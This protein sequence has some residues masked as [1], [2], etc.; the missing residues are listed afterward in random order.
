MDNIS[1][2]RPELRMKESGSRMPPDR[3][4][5]PSEAGLTR[6]L[7]CA[8]QREG[9]VWRQLEGPIFNG[10]GKS[11]LEGSEGRHK[12]ALIRGLSGAGRQFLPFVTVPAAPRERR[13]AYGFRFPLARNSGLAPFGG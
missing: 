7:G 1:G 11:G 12:P 2:A 13:P 4:S 10:N 9:I 6:T 8:R 3:S 5:R